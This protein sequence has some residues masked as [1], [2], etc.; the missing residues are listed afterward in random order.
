[1]YIFI[2]RNIYALLSKFI[3]EFIKRQDVIGTSEGTYN[4]LV[5]PNK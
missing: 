5:Q 2:D 3:D 4:E 1:M